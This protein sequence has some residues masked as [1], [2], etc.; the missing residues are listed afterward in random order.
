MATAH[1]VSIEKLG[2]FFYNR[3]KGVRFLAL[4]LIL[5]LILVDSIEV[6]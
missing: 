5:V 1:T 2:W 3:L 4:R 6:I